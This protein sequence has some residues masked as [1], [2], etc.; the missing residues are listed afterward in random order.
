MNKTRQ[1]TTA[2]KRNDTVIS[3]FATSEH[4]QR[5]FVR[6]FEQKGYAFVRS[7]DAEPVR[8][9]SASLMHLEDWRTMRMEQAKLRNAWGVA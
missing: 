5:V 1:A 9:P 6:K 8:V 3:K 7:G 2:F 4:E